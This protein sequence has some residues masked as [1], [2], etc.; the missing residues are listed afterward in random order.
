[1]SLLGLLGRL[2]SLFALPIYVLEIF[3]LS[4]VGHVPFRVSFRPLNS[5]FIGAEFFFLL[6]FLAAVVVDLLRHVDVS[7]FFVFCRSFSL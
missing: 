4:T 2:L 6:V 7:G 3:S 5:S 1:M